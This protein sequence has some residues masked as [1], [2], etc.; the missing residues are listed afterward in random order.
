MKVFK[1]TDGGKTWSTTSPIPG[2]QYNVNV[3][4]DANNKINVI[5]NSSY[6]S[7]PNIWGERSIYFTKEK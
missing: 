5:S 6:G 7:P 4:F 3:A 2:N 1:S